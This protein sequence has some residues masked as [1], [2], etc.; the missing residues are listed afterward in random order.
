M[1]ETRNAILFT[2]LAGRISQEVAIIDQLIQKKKLILSPEQTFLAGINSGSLNICA[3]NACF[4]K[5]N[6]IN[7]ENDYKKGFLKNLSNDSIYQ[8]SDDNLWDHSHLK[9]TIEAMLWD[10]NIERLSDLDFNSF[11]LTY[12][13]EKEKTFW[14]GSHRNWHED[15]SVRDLI[16]SSMAIPNI[17]TPKEI[18]GIDNL[19]TG[20]PLGAYIDAASHGNFKHFKK[21]LRK[22]TKRNGKFE[23]LFVLSPMRENNTLLD[24]RKLYESA[25]VD[26]NL[27]TDY[28]FHISKAGFNKFLNKL[29]KANQNNNFAESIYVCIPEMD[30]NFDF[31]DYE[32][33]LQKH[34]KVYNWFEDHPDRLA[35]EINQYLVNYT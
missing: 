20:L 30:S 3:I 16:L 26:H 33:Q 2:G 28:I 31:F 11:I 12:S 24:T 5:S 1:L 6:P 13:V 35:I 7:W 34:R 18:K 22:E 8:K 4:R 23:K 15:I 9:H 10:M 32:N 19:P 17:Y 27:L 21:K 29:Q 14:A 25:Q